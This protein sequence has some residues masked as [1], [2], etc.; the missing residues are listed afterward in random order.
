MNNENSFTQ[1]ITY[2][3]IRLENPTDFCLR[4]IFECGQCFRFSPL[5]EDKAAYGGVAHGKYLK[6]AQQQS[7]ILLYTNEHDFRTVW[8][9]FFDLALNYQDCQST[10]PHDDHLQTAAKVAKGIRILHQEHWE[11]L[12]SF[13]LSQ[14]NNIPRIRSLIEALCRAYGES[15]EHDGGKYY[16]FPT[17]DAIAQATEAELRALKVGFRAGYIAD[18]ARRIASGDIDLTAIEAMT[19]EK[20]CSELCKIR[21][22]G[23]KVASCVLL[24][25]YRKYDCFPTDVWV[26]RIL[27]KY[28]PSG[29]DGRYFGEYAGIA[30][31]YLF[32]YE[33]NLSE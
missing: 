21:G 32:H 9:D 29:T 4:D 11:T 5:N 6:I 16:A 24:F 26:K 18:A 13:I 27:E 12:C 25:S 23:P 1:T 10:F 2:S 17:V 22:V 19:T 33:R 28:Y 20:A 7:D 30:Q 31:Q 8:Y 14:N 15:F 3:V